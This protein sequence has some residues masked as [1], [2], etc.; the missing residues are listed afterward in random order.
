MRFVRC[1]DEIKIFLSNQGKHY[2]EWNDEKWLVDLLF[3]TDITTHLNKLNLRLQGAG[4]T[5]LDLFETWES[6][7]AKLDVYIQDVQSFTFRYFKNLQKFSCDHK[8][9][10][11]VIASV[12]LL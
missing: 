4:Q 6:F 1:L 7:V 8:V 11:S 10:S 12:T 9:N 5:V 2:P 3:L